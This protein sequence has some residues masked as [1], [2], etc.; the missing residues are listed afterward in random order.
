M[1]KAIFFALAFWMG[2][3]AAGS[4]LVHRCNTAGE[5][6]FAGDWFTCTPK[7]IKDSK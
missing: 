1:N 7:A 2:A 5:M 4:I 3:V 6:Y